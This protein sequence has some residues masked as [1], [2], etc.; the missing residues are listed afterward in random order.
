MRSIGTIILDVYSY[1]SNFSSLELWL[2]LCHFFPLFLTFYSQG[3][4]SKKGRSGDESSNSNILEEVLS[5]LEWVGSCLKRPHVLSL[6]IVPHFEIVHEKTQSSSTCAPMWRNHL[7][8]SPT[9]QLV[10]KVAWN[11]EIKGR[12]R[13]GRWVWLKELLAVKGDKDEQRR[14]FYLLNG[15]ESELW[16]L[17]RGIPLLCKGENLKDLWA[18]FWEETWSQL[19]SGF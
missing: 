17:R 16:D 9:E 2:N 18:I 7:S 4:S 8:S 15:R 11:V 19:Q 10:I 5:L 14:N 12:T 13:G 3:T 6:L 1:T